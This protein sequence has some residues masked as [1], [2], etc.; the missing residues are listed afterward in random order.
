MAMA[1]THRLKGFKKLQFEQSL[2][3]HILRMHPVLTKSSIRILWNQILGS[4][5]HHP[6]QPAIIDSK[7]PYLS[8]KMKQWDKGFLNNA[9]W[10]S[11]QNHHLI[12]YFKHR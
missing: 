8:V 10:K 4:K 11:V 1:E 6:K 12:M 2:T 9:L 3:H 7:P 5:T